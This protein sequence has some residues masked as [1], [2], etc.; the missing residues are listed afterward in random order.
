MFET[1]LFRASDLQTVMVS[2]K[3]DIYIDYETATI[4]LVVGFSENVF[5]GIERARRRHRKGFTTA[6]IMADHGKM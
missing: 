5:R 1:G 6:T 4:P 2:V 3:Q